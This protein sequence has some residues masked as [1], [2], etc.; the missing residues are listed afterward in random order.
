MLSEQCFTIIVIIVKNSKQSRADVVA[1]RFSDN[2]SI[3][4]SI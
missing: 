3:Y 4:Q 2:I 1:H